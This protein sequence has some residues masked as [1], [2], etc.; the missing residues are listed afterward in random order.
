MIKMVKR[1]K[2][3]VTKWVKIR[4][5]RF[6]VSDWLGTLQVC[7]TEAEAMSWL[8]SCGPTAMIVDRWNGEM[9]V[10]RHFEEI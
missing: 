4:V 2:R 6:E 7:W 5:G 3:M 1:A 10:F 9:V 8:S